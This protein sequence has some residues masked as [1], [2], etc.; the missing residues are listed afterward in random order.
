MASSAT[1][2]D[3]SCP[4][5]S[6]S[7]IAPLPAASTPAVV[8][9]SSSS[10]VVPHSAPSSLA[11]LHRESFGYGSRSLHSSHSHS[12]SSHPSAPPWMVSR[13]K[14]SSSLA[15]TSRR[16]SPA[17]HSGIGFAWGSSAK[18]NAPPPTA[19]SAASAA[20]GVPVPAASEGIPAPL[21]SSTPLPA[22]SSIND[23]QLGPPSAALPRILTPSS[24]ELVRTNAADLKMS[25]TGSIASAPIFAANSP[26]TN[27]VHPPS[28]PAADSMAFPKFPT[29]L[30]PN[31][32]L[33]GAEALQPLS[34]NDVPPA[35]TA[36]RRSFPLTSLTLL[37][38]SSNLGLYAAPTLA[39]SSNNLYTP[40]G[41]VGTVGTVGAVGAMDALATS[42]NPV[43]LLAPTVPHGTSADPPVMRSSDQ[44]TSPTVMDKKQAKGKSKGINTKQKDCKPL[45]RA[46]ACSH[47]GAAFARNHD[48]R[49]YVFSLPWSL[50]FSVEPPSLALDTYHSSQPY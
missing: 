46:F 31:S 41:T 21:S 16:P 18:S 17:F 42:S 14:V 2:L 22:L 28:A 50:G 19:T 38:D 23:Q 26:E 29:W 35:P 40:V 7:S 49:R 27:T 44:H 33:S 36:R 3:Y 34:S 8:R 37:Q 20:S 12:H 25:P 45:P 39:G 43:P 9:N 32:P 10:S 5:P 11:S 30:P 1:T 4:Y 6:P 13:D 47:C 48:L 15:P 24:L